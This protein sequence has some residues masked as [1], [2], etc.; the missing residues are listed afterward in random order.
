MK[1]KISLLMCLVL[2]FSA[3]TGCD[4]NFNGIT[5][6]TEG[7][8]TAAVE[9]AVTQKASAA[10]AATAATATI[11]MTTTT[12]TTAATTTTTTAT[13]PTTTKKTTTKAPATVPTTKAPEKIEKPDTDRIKD[14][15]KIIAL[16]FDDG[17]S[18]YTA[19]LLD[20]LEENGAHATF[21]VLGNRAKNNSELLKRMLDEGH[22]I[23]SHTWDHTSFA[24][25]SYNSALENMKK[26]TNAIKKASGKKPVLVRPPYGAMS[27]SLKYAATMQGQ[28]IITWSVDP[29]DW[30]TKNP[31]T[32]YNKIMSNVSDGD[33]ILCHDIHK[34]TVDAMERVIPDLID[35]GYTLVTVSELLTYERDE[36]T[37]GKVYSKRKI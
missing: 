8:T 14:G 9:A 32:V 4:I 25:L 2:I 31:D 22:E 37:A 23:G 30:D 1:K 10:Q 3:F 18:K 35:E 24:K 19:R 15:D 28:A 36:L 7:S 27:D 17:P 12:T 34:S 29:R 16:T 11:T 26:A 33:I 6:T 13:K 20:I 5:P 21:F